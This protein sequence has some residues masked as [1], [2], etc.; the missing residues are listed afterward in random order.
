MGNVFREHVFYEYI[1]R[2]NVFTNIIHFPYELFILSNH[3]RLLS[4]YSLL[5]YLYPVKIVFNVIKVKK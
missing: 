4:E 1:I 5:S 2:N 3:Y